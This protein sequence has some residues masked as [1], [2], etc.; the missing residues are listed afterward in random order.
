MLTSPG[1]LADGL[2]AQGFRAVKIWPFDQF[3]PEYDSLLG[4]S[5]GPP[6]HYITNRQLDAGL[7]IVQA[8]QEQVADMEILIDGHHRWDINSAIR[9]GRALEPYRPLWMEDMTLSDNAGD[10]RRLVEETRVPILAS[11][12]LMTVFPYRTL[13]E[14]HAV[15]VVMIDISFVG[16]LTEARNVA[17]LAAAYNLPITTHDCNGPVTAF[18]N[19]HFSAATE[20]ATI[21]ECAR[22][23]FDGGWYA[24]VVED[25]LPISGGYATVPKSPGLGTRLRD[26]LKASSDVERRSTKLRK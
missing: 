25:R 13:L 21:T 15:H 9:I 10:L 2:A 11:E 18:A 24:E 26:D 20:N 8:I 6:G 5:H 4:R 23:H 3:A 17:A 16:G 14:N 1:E 7:R 12:R 22:A 19:L